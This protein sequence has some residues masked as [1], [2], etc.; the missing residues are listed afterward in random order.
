M[1]F[2][3]K[4]TPEYSKIYFAMVTILILDFGIRANTKI[5]IS[6]NP[7]KHKIPNTIKTT[8]RGKQK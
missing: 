7:K 3:L 1:H 5:Y 4:Q 8:E 2:E 6:Q